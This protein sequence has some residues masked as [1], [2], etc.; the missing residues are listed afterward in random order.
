MQCRR[1]ALGVGIV[2]ACWVLP[3]PAASAQEHQHGAAVHVGGMAVGLWTLADPAFAGDRLSE[4]YL[5]QPMLFGHVS[6]AGGAVAVLATINLEGIT[7]R[8]GELAA[9]NAG[10]GY[11]D[12]RHPHTFVHEAVV[13]TRAPSWHGLET[14]LAVGRGFVPF[15]TDDPMVRPFTKYPTNHHLAQVLE[16]LIVVGAVRRGP[17]MLEASVFNGDEPMRS[18]DFGRL[19]RF[20]DSWSLRATVQPLRGLE[21][22]SSLASVASPEHAFGGGLDHRKRSASARLDTSP[23]PGVELY[24]LLEWARTDEYSIGRRFF[25][26]ESA[27][28]ELAAGRGG[29]GGALRLERTTRPEEERLRDPFRSARPHADE[30]IVGITR[31]T[32]VTGRVEKTFVTRS[33]GWTLEP[34]VEMA[35]HAVRQTEGILFDPVAQFGSDRLWNVSLGARIGGGMRHSRMGRYGVALHGSTAVQVE[36]AARP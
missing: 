15:G 6:L 12:R 35:R 32:S 11:V 28:A 9:G 29:W 30:N 5:T 34:F 18:E 36:T 20:G 26:F 4:A 31:W 24:A 27:L 10:E 7:L 22:Q 25:R 3:V 16:R 33:G 14:S 2:A 23:V 17:I 19:D 21:L 13:V 1:W 8:R